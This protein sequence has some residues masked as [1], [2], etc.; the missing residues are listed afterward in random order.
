MFDCSVQAPIN[1]FKRSL[2]SH[3]LPLLAYL[4]K[5]ECVSHTLS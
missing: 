3:L 2:L 5:H 4:V 1:V